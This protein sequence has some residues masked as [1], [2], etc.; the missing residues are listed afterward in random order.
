LVNLLTDLAPA[1]AIALRPPDTSA[2]AA[3]LAEGPEASLGAA[4]P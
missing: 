2:G 1:L 4:P 3:L